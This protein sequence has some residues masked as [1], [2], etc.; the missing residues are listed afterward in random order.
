MRNPVEGESKSRTPPGCQGW[1]NFDKRTIDR[2]SS[3][4]ESPVDCLDSNLLL[5][6]GQW[7][8]GELLRQHYRGRRLALDPGR[9]HLFRQRLCACASEPSDE[10]GKGTFGDGSFTPGHNLV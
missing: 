4:S 3:C 2:A 9:Q 8:P 5:A 1:L 6:R 7:M 10:P